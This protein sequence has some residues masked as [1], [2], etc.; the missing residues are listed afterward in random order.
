MIQKYP[1]HSREGGTSPITAGAAAGALAA[2][3]DDEDEEEGARV[4]F[5]DD[6]TI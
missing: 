2:A 3:P 1:R 4:W 5:G 6:E